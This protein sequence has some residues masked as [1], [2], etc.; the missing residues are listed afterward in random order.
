[1]SL[2]PN[3]DK[4]IAR[5]PLNNGDNDEDSG[6]AYIAYGVGMRHTT[7]RDICSGSVKLFLNTSIFSTA[8]L[9]SR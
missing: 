6:S 1:M 8:H 5:A 2:D 3:S 4:V 7:V 9:W